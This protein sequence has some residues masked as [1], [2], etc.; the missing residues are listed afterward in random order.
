MLPKAPAEG[1]KAQAG[2]AP[3][4]LSFASN[5]HSQ[6]QFSPVRLNI[7]SKVV[8]APPIAF[9]A[10]SDDSGCPANVDSTGY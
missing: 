1:W 8:K 3:I 2:S 4:S 10:R 7:L 5:S 6:A 9:P